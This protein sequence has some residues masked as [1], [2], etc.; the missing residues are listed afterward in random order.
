LTHFISCAC[1]LLNRVLQT[2]LT[3]TNSAPSTPT[4][5]RTPNRRNVSISPHK[6]PSKLGP[7]QKR[8]LA[9]HQDLLTRYKLLEAKYDH[10]G[11]RYDTL[12]AAN[13]ALTER[14]RM[15]LAK[16]RKLQ[17]WLYDYGNEGE[18]LKTSAM[19]DKEKKK[20]RQERLD[21]KRRRF[22]E[23]KEKSKVE[24]E[25]EM[26]HFDR[27]L[28]LDAQFDMEEPHAPQ[29]HGTIVPPAG[30]SLEG[31]LEAVAFA[32]PESIFTEPLS[33]PT[34]TP[35]RVSLKQLVFIPRS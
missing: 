34:T 9:S 24:R 12:H 18:A 28:D 14:Y 23:L 8:L 21:F 29:L 33:S 6:S 31:P 11:D 22:H 27:L 19:N 30:T 3:P 2:T 17:V 10:T 1:S 26:G 5:P 15:E 32:N 16:W 7:E 20:Y 35:R 4:K 25:K 13:Q